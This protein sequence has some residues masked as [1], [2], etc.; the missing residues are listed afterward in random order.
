MGKTNLKPQATA[1]ELAHLVPETHRVILIEPHSHFHHLF[2]FPRFAVVAGQE[3]KAFIPYSGLFSS[4]P[5]SS[6]H[7]V[8]RARVLSVYPQ[9]LKLDREWNGSC[10]IPFEYLVIA[11]GTRLAEPAGMKSDDKLSSVAYLQKHQ[12][13]VKQAK[14]ILIGG[15]GAV[16]VQMATDLKEYYPDKEITL[17]QSRPRLMPGF[18]MKL[19]DL[20]QER[21]SELGIK[22]ITGTR[23]LIPKDGVPKDGSSFVV[24]LSNGSQVSTNFVILA[25]G[26]TPNSDLIQTLVPSTADP[27]INPENGFIRIRPTMQLQDP[28]YRNIFAVGDI[29][30]TGLRKAARPG[31]A[32]A[33]VVARN[34]HALINGKITEET[35][36]RMPAA[37]HLTL[38]MKYNVIFRNPSEAEGQTEPTIIPK[39]DGHQDMNIEGMWQKLGVHVQ[40][41]NQYH[42]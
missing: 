39:F 6:R 27:L 35:Y 34:I 5:N 36:P 9:V 32:Q 26:Q 3:H 16:G 1:Q 11:T 33:A 14:S 4:I 21:F 15:G 28:L 20:I 42:L 18:H 38:G 10:Q 23:L 30:D 37:I 17:V 19:H 31:S 7:A 25:T 8:A 22:L 29:A 2:A 40:S 12:K 24:K 13:D 41:T